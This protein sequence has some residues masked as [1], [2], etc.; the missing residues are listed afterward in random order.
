MNHLRF[1]I[2]QLL[3]NPGFS[4][5]AVITLALGLGACTAT[6]SLF[7]A[8]LLK[9]LPF[10]EPERL[11]WIQNWTHGSFSDQATRMD[12]LLD[13]R[14]HA[15]SFDEI[16]G[17]SPFYATERNV[18][19][20]DGPPKRV[21]G[22]KISQNFLEVLG[23]KL[24]KGRNFV[25]EECLPNGSQAVIISHALWRQHFVAEPN[26][27][28]KTTTINGITV[29][30]VGV[31]PPAAF[32]ELVLSPGNPPDILRPL[33]Q[34]GKILEWGNV[35]IGVGRLNPSSN[36]DL[37]QKE[38]ETFTAGVRAADPGRASYSPEKGPTL[39]PLDQYIRGNVKG[40][41]K[42]LICAVLFV[43]FIACINLSNLLLARADR[44]QQEF[45][46]R[47]A[48][49]ASRRQL[50]SQSMTESLILVTAGCTAGTLAAV[51][52][53]SLLSK[54]DLFDIPLLH[55][56][57][58]DLPVL[59]VALL[60]AF[61]SALCCGGLPALRLWRQDAQSLAK[62]SGN[63][64][65]SGKESIG[66]RQYL[67]ITELALACILL[68]FAGLLVRS[69]LKV[70]QLDIGFR[71]E[72]V[73]S[74]QIDSGR[75]FES[76]QSRN[77]YYREL[78][79]RIAIVNGVELVSLSDSIPFGFKRHWPLDAKGVSYQEG[80]H[81]GGYV[82]FIDSQCLQ[83][84]NTALLRGRYFNNSDRIGSEPVVIISQSLANR[85]WK[86][87]DPLG[88]TALVNDGSEYKVIGIVS[89]VAHGLDGNTPPDFYLSYH[90][91]ERPHWSSPNLMFRTTTSSP[92]P[93]NDVRTA[94]HEFDA[95]LP[96]NEFIHL[97]NIVDRAI[98]PRRFMMGT[99][100]AFSVSALL[101]A[102]IGLYGLI[103][104]N[105]GARTREFGIR[106]AVGAQKKDVLWMV[107]RGVV[108]MSGVGMAI[109]LLGALTGT[110][111]L[112][113]QLFG[114]PA[115]DPFTYLA[116]LTLLAIVTLFAAL[117]PARSAAMVN[118]N[119]ALR[120]E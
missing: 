78:K 45:S 41:F 27:I 92:S 42:M 55:T 16:A 3:R 119:K 10:F 51:F 53:V 66:F 5:V 9:P 75:E 109:G 115:N 67:V 81:R 100:I 59:A 49:G 105:V 32:L 108:K 13:W 118:P 111:L 69:F 46:L 52:G 62:Y 36:I 71:T 101:L 22:I 104:Y 64:G 18:L 1:T 50:L 68:I 20:G 80:D 86:N 112:Q 61:L 65:T 19:S 21:H 15:Q 87:E 97:T 57:S 56:A 102:A 72:Q 84:M 114:V 58:V 91:W 99:L 83:T 110:R 47:A 106:I 103:A 29:S 14:T 48:L 107:I 8:V 35:V 96:T 117:F 43:W 6:F 2:R 88:K 60:M 30:V 73:Y 93:L 25:H 44:K 26:I 74:W 31:L 70:T 79:Q 12:N 4:A 38:L 63:R 82:R 77:H 37:A 40:G 120:D 90:Q 54:L 94:I 116:T 76:P 113:N 17:F 98:A 39:V 89:D 28:G 7:H 11:V 24:L 33:P 95:N 85:A 23:V 34:T